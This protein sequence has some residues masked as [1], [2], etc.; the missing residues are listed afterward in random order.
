M[1]AGH[2]IHLVSLALRVFYEK[3]NLHKGRTWAGHLKTSR[4]ETGLKDKIRDFR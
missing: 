1:E 2:L 3:V 4:I